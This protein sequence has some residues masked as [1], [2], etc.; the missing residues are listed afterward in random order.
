MI[1]ELIATVVAGVGAA[2]IALFLHRLKPTRFPR[3]LIP[4][5]AGAGMLG[6]SIYGEYS[7]FKHTEN[8][9]PQGVKVVHVVDGSSWWRPW[10][11]VA[12]HKLQF[13]AL[14]T[15]S[16][17]EN[18]LNPEFIRIDLYF[19]EY[20]HPTRMLRQIVDCQRKKRTAFS[21]NLVLPPTGAVSGSEWQALAVDDKIYQLSC[22]TA[23]TT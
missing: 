17:T 12:P 4:F 13:V 18:T 7:W 15:N 2:G 5:F 11:F 16:R 8:R 3:Y 9:L 14:D 10:S 6:F 21:E 19:F 1:W 23:K 20:R 22:Q